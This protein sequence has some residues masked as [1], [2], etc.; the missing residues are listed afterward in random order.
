MSR[1]PRMTEFEERDFYAAPRRSAPEFEEIDR[2]RTITRS[3]PRSERNTPAFLR[4][5]GRRSEAGPMVLRQRDVE[6]FDR[7]HRSPS[8]VRYVQERVVR[9][10]KSVSPQRRY[11]EHDHEHE[12]S[13]TRIVDR[14]RIR[15]PSVERRRSPSTA[16]IRYVE[17]PR[18]EP[19]PERVRTR[20]VDRQRERSLSSSSS[21]SSEAPKHIRGPTIEREVITH[22]KDIDHGTYSIRTSDI[23]AYILTSCR[24]REGK[25]SEPTPNATCSLSR[26]GPRA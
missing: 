17:R 7:H 12:R 26:P 14:E 1:A 18:R 22:Y 8:P 3:P 23:Y 9:R 10:P 15:S 2:R 21:S 25:A 20:I 24:R 19:S 13:R 6:T 4:D 16:P 5:D 11:P